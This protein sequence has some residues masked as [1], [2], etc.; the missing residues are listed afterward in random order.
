MIEVRD[1]AGNVV[2]TATSAVTAS[3]ASGGGAI[4]GAT[5]VNAAGGV[6][7]FTSLVV[8]GAIGD[9]TLT[10]SASGLASVA[11]S[12]FAL[13][14][15]APTQLVVRTQPNGAAVGAP[16]T[17][18]PVVELRDAAGNLSTASTLAVT[19]T[20]NSGGGTLGGAITAT[21]VGGVATFNTL[22]LSGTVGARTLNFSAAGIPA[23]TSASFILAAGAPAS[24][25]VRTPPTGGGL[26]SPFSPSP[27]IEVRDASGN[28]ST[29]ASTV[30]TASLVFG[31]G[32]LSGT[33]AT[34]LNGVATFT[35][36]AVNGVA[37]LR[38]LSFGAAGLASVTANVRP[39]DA[40]RA[41]QLDVGTTSRTLS[42]ISNG[43]VV[44][45]SLR[46]TDT[47]GSCAA[48]AGVQA[49]VTPGTGGN[50]LA[51]AIVGTQG[52]LELRANPTALAPGTYTATVTLSSTNSG[53]LTLAATLTVQPS[54]PVTYGDSTQKLTQLDPNGTIK[55]TTTVRNSGGSVV[56]LPVTY[57]SRSPSLA[58][59]S[60][61]GTITALADGQAWVI[62]R[63]TGN[64]GAT[65]SVFVNITRGSG[66]VLRTDATRL[67]YQRGST[68]SILVQLDTRG[69]TVGAAQVV[70][71]WPSVNDTPGLLQLLSVTPGT[72]GTT[73]ITSDTNY[74]TT[75]IAV[76]NATGMKGLITLARLDF[77]AANGGASQFTTRFIEL[78]ATDQVSLIGNASALLYPVIVK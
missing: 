43:A 26:N 44:V 33:S 32:T 73:A 7:T 10:F 28:V 57:Q 13:Q 76:I 11:S 15:G 34:A 41:P 22:T 46:I 69:L 42:A 62:A 1:A 31:G 37:G 54:F 20:I 49:T 25:A 60:P 30:V 77:S 24:L 39:C 45:D 52:I 36:L 16:L 51:A 38:T 4:S 63:V 64:G 17:T 27:V 23:A 2:P 78:L 3:L 40:G 12:T 66:P 74:G 56:S 59:V 48:I 75:R 5:T 14:A 65:D 19:T 61:D 18:Q 8:D 47:V 9:R 21:A 29:S 58:S 67:V 35:T 72:A 70:F 6:A 55:P 53:S 68:F 50:W 71:T